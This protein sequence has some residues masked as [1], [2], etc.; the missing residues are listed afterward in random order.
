VPT[1]EFHCPDCGSFDA[2][3]PMGRATD[4]A[5]C[6]ACAEPSRRVY[7]PPGTRRALGPLSG[8][9]RR[10]AARIDRARTGEPVVTGPPGGRRLPRRAPHPH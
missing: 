1:Y 5:P 9:G 4:P 2:Q 8:A 7:T 6:P 3:R 10:E